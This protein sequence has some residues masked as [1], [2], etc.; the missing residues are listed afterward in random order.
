MRLILRKRWKKFCVHSNF[1]GFGHGSVARGRGGK[2]KSRDS[3]TGEKFFEFVF[4]KTAGE[5]DFL[6]FVLA[7]NLFD[8]LG[9][10]YDIYEVGIE[11]VAFNP[12]TLINNICQC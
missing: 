12:L 8:G 9:V 3:D 4:Y 5:K 11:T 1:F 10:I 2:S 7:Q 6:D